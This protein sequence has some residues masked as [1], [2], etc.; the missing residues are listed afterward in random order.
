MGILPK[1]PRRLKEIAK[2][3]KA[4]PQWAVLLDDKAWRTDKAPKRPQKLR[5]PKP[6]YRPCEISDASVPCWDALPQ[7]SPGAGRQRRPSALLRP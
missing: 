6:P 4:R 3:K 5:Q 1:W 7:R 2:K